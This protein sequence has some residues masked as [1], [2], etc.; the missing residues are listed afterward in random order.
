MIVIIMNV[1]PGQYDVRGCSIE[2]PPLNAVW[3]EEELPL[4]AASL[5][6]IRFSVVYCGTAQTAVETLKYLRRYNASLEELGSIRSMRFDPHRTYLSAELER[7]AA[8]DVVM[9]TVPGM[10]D[11]FAELRAGYCKDAVHLVITGWQQFL[12][13][14]VALG[15]LEHFEDAALRR[16]L[17]HVGEPEAGA[18]LVMRLADPNRA[19]IE[20]A[21]ESLLRL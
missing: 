11:F 17:G 1:G 2:D 8:A 21:L 3:A 4:I 7:G 5:T 15:G 20:I 14:K 10:I 6:A 19:F 18:F 12:A 13:C 16:W 9:R